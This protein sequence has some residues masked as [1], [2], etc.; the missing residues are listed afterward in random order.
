M[1][2]GTLHYMSRL[3]RAFLSIA[4]V[5]A[6]AGPVQASSEEAPIAIA[7]M[8][9]F[10]AGGQIVRNDAGAS[11]S[12]DHG[13]V[14]YQI[15]AHARAV[16]LLLW[17][18]SS[19]AVWQR[20][21]DGGEGFQSMFLRRGYP[22]YVWDGPR[23]GRANWGCEEYTYKPWLGRDQG[24]FGSWRLGAR[25]PGWFEGVQF[26]TGDAEAWNQAVRARYN[27]FDTVKNAQLEATAA[28]AALERVGPSVL[29]TNSA[30]GFRAMLTALKSD[31]VKGIVAY[32]TP[33]F[34]FPEGEGPRLEE[35]RFGPVYV[36]KEEFLKLT[37][38]PI[39]L[40]WGDNLDKSESWTE[41][42]NLGQQ[43][44]DLINANGGRAEM[45]DLP[46]KGLRGNTHI[47]FADLNNAEVADLMADFL[48]R[49]QLDG[50][51]ADQ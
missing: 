47:P 17:H 31:N 20:R 4:G 16:S 2:N 42:R 18:S 21:W 46:S 26:P 6:M 45:L 44:V 22:V 36:P 38:F 3:A 37:R 24:S 50:R 43:F 29:V 35:G 13:H 12:C 34:V 10:E 7:K 49:H 23:V 28:A 41:F 15:P 19:A 11:I 30:G 1:E 32:E 25:Y 27:E 51:A 39:Q 14:E 8:G 9:S 48:H 5:T 40:V 33:G